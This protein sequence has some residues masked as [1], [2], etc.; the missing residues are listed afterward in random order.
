MENTIKKLQK[1]LLLCAALIFASCTTTTFY[2]PQ[3]KFTKEQSEPV[4][5]GVVELTILKGRTTS[6]PPNIITD[7][8]TAYKRG[9]GDATKSIKDFCGGKPVLQTVSK[10]VRQSGLKGHT[11]TYI[12]SYSSFST[13]TFTPVYRKYTNISFEC[14]LSDQQKK[15]NAL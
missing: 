10:E 4:K 6:P 15:D 9:W 8:D 2:Y 12:G 13:T 3:H 1:F 5:R 14:S 7:R 11:S